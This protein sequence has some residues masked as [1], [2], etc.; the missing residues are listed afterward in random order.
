MSYLIHLARE[1][2]EPQVSRPD[3]AKVLAGDPV[4]TDWPHEAEEGLYA[5]IWQATPGSWSV[6]Y[7]EW[8]YF[9]ILAGL[10]IL[11]D[12]E[13]NATRLTPGT[14]LI[15]RPGFTGTWQVVETTLKDYVIRTFAGLDGSTP[16]P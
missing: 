3:P 2:A 4:F 1:N 9:H 13:G 6:S 11:T 10:S 14:R 16:S 15:L 7:A 5:G 12:A 8:E